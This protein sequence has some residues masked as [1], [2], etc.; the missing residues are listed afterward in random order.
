MTKTVLITG[1]SGG[2]GYQTALKF[3]QNKYNIIYH[4]NEHKNEEQIT[5]LTALTNVLPIKADLTNPKDIFKLY[6]ESIKTFGKIDCLV[7]NAGIDRCKLIIDEDYNA[8]QNL[9][10]A[11]LTS[12]IYLTSLVSKNMANNQ[13][14]NI[15]NISSV[16]AKTGGATESV[17]SATKSALVGF[18][19]SL[20]SELSYCGIRVNC[21]APGITDTNMI[22]NLNKNEIDDYTNTLAIKRVADP[23][24]IANVI[25][26]LAS[27]E[28]SYITGQTIYVD[29]GAGLS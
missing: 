27:K 20:A 13:N 29:G 9:I 16:Y 26:F 5:A 8:I 14:G 1:A 11:N 25:F 23:S 12:V 28:S 10:S 15:I 21:I 17:Y 22:S 6:N 2:I 19:K 18:T 4:Y 24:E 7:N 3:A